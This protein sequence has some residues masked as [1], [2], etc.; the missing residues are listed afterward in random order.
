MSQKEREGKKT[1]GSSGVKIQS[2]T[3]QLEDPSHLFLGQ[4]KQMGHRPQHVLSS[5]AARGKLQ[6]VTGVA[7]EQNSIKRTA[8]QN[9]LV[10]QSGKWNPG[11][12]AAEGAATM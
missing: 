9:R 10:L 11:K 5:L 8:Y 7:C 6:Q 3:S 4:Q 2:P 12:A 1:A